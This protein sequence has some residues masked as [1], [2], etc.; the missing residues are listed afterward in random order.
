M[1]NLP[2]ESYKYFKSIYFH[3]HRISYGKER[4]E[5]QTSIPE[6]DNGYILSVNI[7]NIS[8]NQNKWLILIPILLHP[9]APPLFFLTL[10]LCSTI[11]HQSGCKNSRRHIKSNIPIN[12]IAARG[13][14]RIE[15]K[16]KRKKR[17]NL[18]H[19]FFWTGN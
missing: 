8:F 6:P 2:C 13:N 10:R 12:T 17:R 15:T 4:N 5:N 18:L 1:K 3:Y 11:A 7:T 14:H 19:S 16:A 9:F